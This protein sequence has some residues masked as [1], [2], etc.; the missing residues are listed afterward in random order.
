MKYNNGKKIYDDSIE[1]A[2]DALKKYNQ[3]K[4]VSTEELAEPLENILAKLSEFDDDIANR[5]IEYSENK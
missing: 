1:V 5:F 2:F 4:G 3:C